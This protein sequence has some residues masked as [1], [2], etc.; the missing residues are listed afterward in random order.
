MEET[1]TH[2][3]LSLMILMFGML[4]MRVHLLLLAM[5]HQQ[6]LLMVILHP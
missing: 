5:L 6:S 3:P 1:L 4:R 2:C